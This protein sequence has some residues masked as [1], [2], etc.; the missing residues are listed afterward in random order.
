MSDM[1]NSFNIYAD[2]LPFSELDDFIMDDSYSKVTL[3]VIDKCVFDSFGINNEQIHENE[4][5]SL[6]LNSLRET[7]LPVSKYI[8]I[9]DARQTS[10][11]F[12]IAS[13]NIRSIPKNFELFLVNYSMP[14][15][16]F[17][18]VALCET[19]MTKN[20]IKKFNT[21]GYITY[22]KCRNRKG[23]GVALMVRDIHQSTSLEDLCFTYPFLECVAVEIA[24]AG[25]KSIFASIYRPPDGD[26]ELFLERMEFI[27][28]TAR[29]KN[30]DTIYIMGDSNINLLG[31]SI[32]KTALINLMA[33]YFCFSVTT[34][35]T[36]I[37]SDTYTLIDQIWTSNNQ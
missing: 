21:N 13:Y 8:S 24:I 4:E 37:T 20:L 30:F 18:V 34:K 29:E 28:T 36:R 27:L 6:Y 32:T 19:R 5:D 31:A 35:P 7:N 9:E 1:N 3:D 2:A 25:K 22:H 10:E 15:L 33:S 23:G 11:A 26:E 14:K 12:K 16:P 17:D